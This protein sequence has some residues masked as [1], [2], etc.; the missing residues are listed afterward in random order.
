MFPVQDQALSALRGGQ[1][2]NAALAQPSH[3]AS[4]FV[5]KGID[6]RPERMLRIMGYRE[7]APVRPAVYRT[8]SAMAE[9]AQA[10]IA[11]VI[12]DCRVT[13][14]RC[15]NDGLLLSDGTAFRG[16]VFAKYL[17][18]CE[19]AVAFIL[20]LGGR[21]DSTAKNLVSGGNM[22]EAVFLETAGWV[23]VEGATQLY[24]DHLTQRVRGE[25]MQLTRR[26]APGYSFRV[27]GRKAEWPLEDQKP[28]FGLFAGR[29]LPV[30]IMESCAMTPKMSRTGFYGLR[31][32]PTS[33]PAP[34][35]GGHT[36]GAKR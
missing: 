28:L 32:M 6:I 19:A 12:H 26:L 3:A 23:A 10:A 29:Q 8:A 22:L 31:T 9:L 18:G 36:S 16:P 20:T 25:G 33:I 27:G 34:D 35:L 21:F 30:E 15:D 17:D 1:A 24:A 14:S 13:V 11:P 2:V 7:G 5:P 4:V